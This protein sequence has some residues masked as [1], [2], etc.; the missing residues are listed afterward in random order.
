MSKNPRFTDT[1]HQI[2]IGFG[3]KYAHPVGLCGKTTPLYQTSLGAAFVSDSLTFMQDLPS[4]SVEAVITSPPYALHFK[5]EYGNVDK[6][7]YVDWFLP[8]AAQIKRI[9]K[10]DGSFVLN[11]GGSYNPGSPT[12]SLY[13]FKLLIALCD[14]LGFHL[15]QECFWYNPAKLPA[16]AEW[17][18]VRRVR[19]KDSVEYVWWFSPTEWPKANNHAVLVPYSNDM[20]RLIQKGYRAKKRPSGHNIT[21]KF[22]KDHNGAIPAN[23]ISRGNNESNSEFLRACT[24]NGHKLN[25]ARFPP[26]LPEFFLKLLTDPGD[27]VLDPFAGSNTT[28]FVAESLDRRW[29]SIELNEDYLRASSLRF[30]IDLLR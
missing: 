18:N 23:L 24:A 20:E 30:G 28:G 9:L 13:H 29:L 2:R 1:Q 3:S 4:S 22:R 5:K 7:K 15:A 12:R 10:P 8:F 19:I 11:I 14:D 6:A 16:P 21:E 26:A 27:I 25:P 17:V